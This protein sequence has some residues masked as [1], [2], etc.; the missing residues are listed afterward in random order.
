M[1]DTLDKLVS[2]YE[3]L[4]LHSKAIDCFQRAIEIHEKLLG[5]NHVQVANA[6]CSLA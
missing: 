3:K 2:V 6:L 1:A 5:A 4:E